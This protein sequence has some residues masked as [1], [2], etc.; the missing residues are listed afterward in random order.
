M[1]K[2]REEN[3]TRACSRSSCFERYDRLKTPYQLHKLLPTTTRENAT[4]RTSDTQAHGKHYQSSSLLQVR[5]IMQ[6]A[7]NSNVPSLSWR[8]E[9]Q[10][11]RMRISSRRKAKKRTESEHAPVGHAK[12]GMVGWDFIQQLQ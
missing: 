7:R 8:E 3:R 12:E 4:N 6:S 5:C 1:S 2:G 11:G 9:R 10:H